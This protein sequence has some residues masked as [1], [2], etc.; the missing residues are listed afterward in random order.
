MGDIVRRDYSLLGADSRIAAERGLANADWYRSPVDRKR[1]RQLMERTDRRAIIDTLV[2]LGL[3]IGLGI[4]IAVSWFHWWTPLLMIPYGVLWSLGGD[5]RCHE[6]GHR[7]AFRTRRLN[8]IVFWI[9]CFMAMREPTVRRWD[10]T[11]HHTD[12]TI[13]GR[14]REIVEQ[15]PPRIPHVFLIFTGLPMVL[16]AMR[17]MIRHTFGRIAADER[18]LI[19]ESEWPKLF[20]QCRVIVAIHL[21]IIAL[22]VSTGSI[23]PLVLTSFATCYGAWALF[24]V[25]LTQHVGLAEDVTDF[26]LN[27]RTVYMNFVWRFVYW[28]MNYHLEH[29]MYPMVPFHA[30][31]D[32]HEE[33]KADCPPPYHGNWQVYRTEIIPTLR[34][35]LNDP[36]YHVRRPLPD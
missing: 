23:V 17:G 19:P 1:M 2:W 16:P 15:R 11:R 12:T 31:K 18:L 3:L 34:R 36:S 20:R 4:A 29:H 30:L 26:R 28:N 6:A 25:A 9:G 32:L 13:V 35:Q 8:N 5:S 14:D 33:I 7:T 10:H 21:A 27:T 22:A 24:Y